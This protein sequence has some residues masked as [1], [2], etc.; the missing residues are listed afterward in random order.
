[1]TASQLL[2]ENNSSASEAQLMAAD[3]LA[4]AVISMI[5]LRTQAKQAHWNVTGPSF[6]GI[7]KLLDKLVDELDALTDTTA[8]R[9]RSLGVLTH[10]TARHVAESTRLADLSP[11]VTYD[12]EIIEHLVAVYRDVARQ[13]RESVDATAE[14]DPATSDVFVEVLRALDQHTF[15]LASHL[16]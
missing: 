1:M 9:Q 2:A 16:G 11:E 4:Q 6:I 14:D 7:H 13:I 15:L 10:A 12:N 8:E 5:D 3:H